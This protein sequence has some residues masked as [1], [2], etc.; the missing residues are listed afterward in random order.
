MSEPR[1]IEAAETGLAPSNGRQSAG[2]ML[3][4]MRESAGVDVTLLASAMKVSLQKIEALENDRLEEL[5]DLTFARGLAAAICRAFGA[6]PAPV[7]ERM[8]VATSGLRPQAGKVNAPFKR[9]SDRPAPMLTGS[10]FSKPLLYA[11]IGLLIAAA[12]LWLLPTL[13]I[14]L[15]GPAPAASEPADGQVQESLSPPSAAE[16]TSAAAPVAPASEPA[17]AVT[18][19]PAEPAAPPDLLSFSA[20]G[21]TWVTVRDAA[22]KQ[23]INRALVAGETVG[24]SGEA[25][26]SVTI[27][28]KDAVEVTVRGTPFDH[29]SLSKTTVSRFQVK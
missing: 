14:Q 24:V 27:G 15:S 2:A 6:D 25:P 22:G 7:L 8:P 17:V 12:A 29:R 9:S 28:R 1:A 10:S 18:P 21:E 3:R 5:P 23:L 13:P 19:P 11:V 20:S 16:P 26:L 4:Q